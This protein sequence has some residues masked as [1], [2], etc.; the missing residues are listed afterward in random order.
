MGQK[1]GW[2]CLPPFRGGGAGSPS[3]TMSSWSRITFLPSDIL[4]HRAIW[5]QQVWAETWGEGCA[6]LGH[7]DLGP[8]L[9]VWPG[10]RPACVPSF[11]LILPSVWPQ[12]TN[13]TDRT[14]R[15]T[16]SG[17]IPQG[18]AFYKRSPKNNSMM[19]VELTGWRGRMTTR[20]SENDPEDEEL[21]LSIYRKPSDIEPWLLTTAQHC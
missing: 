4:I 12:C 16:D 3:N 15:Q 7:W 2:L 11:I 21:T 17:P 9:T 19:E 1:L 13:I 8:H 5:P 20:S 14:H 6:P 10:P 18:E